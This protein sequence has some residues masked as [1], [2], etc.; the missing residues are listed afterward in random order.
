MT[1]DVKMWRV[2]GVSVYIS[3][4]CEFI[5]HGSAN[6]SCVLRLI[7]ASRHLGLQGASSS[8]NAPTSLENPF[9]M[10][11]S[12][13]EKL[14]MTAVAQRDSHGSAKSLLLVGVLASCPT[15]CEMDVEFVMA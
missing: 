2:V 13:A 7:L 1:V 4:P 9:D 3:S 15:Y 14:A 12:P 11:H 6:S 10:M 8:R 5:N